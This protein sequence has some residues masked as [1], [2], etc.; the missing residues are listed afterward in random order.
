MMRYFAATAACLLLSGCSMMPEM[1]RQP[2]LHNP[3]PQLTKVAVAPFFNLSHEATLDG[4]RVAAAYFN[5]LQAVPGFEVTPVGIVEQK[6]REHG[7]MLAGPGDA[8]RLAQI[9]DVDAVVIGAVTDYTRYYPPRMALQVEWYTANPCFHT[10]PPGYGLPLGTRET[11]DIPE[12]LIFEAQMAAARAQLEAQ[13]PQFKKAA[14]EVPAGQPAAQAPDEGHPRNQR[15]AHG[16]VAQDRKSGEAFHPVP[17][18]GMPQAW[19]GRVP[20]TPDGKCPQACNPTEKPV[21]QHTRTYN[22]NDGQFIDALKTYYGFREDE[23]MG[24]WQGYLQR[25]EDFMRFCCHMNVWEMLA[26]RGG[27]GPSRVVW[28]WPQK[29][30]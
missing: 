14:M 29:S 15:D 16:L 8:R 30:E 24:G 7:I 3:F 22:G 23:R 4:R 5:E 10:I 17:I 28:R 21:M 18:A 27:S 25:S 13:T 2:T 6:I 1:A 12:P 20:P 11:K 26:A 19:P 9:L